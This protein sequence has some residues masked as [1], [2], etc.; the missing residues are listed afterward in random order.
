MWCIES[1]AV[2]HPGGG[3]NASA[4]SEG[5]LPEAASKTPFAC[6]QQ[7]TAGEPGS[8]VSNQ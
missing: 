2:P 5:E 7:Q 3:S 1:C 8:V 4:A 6:A